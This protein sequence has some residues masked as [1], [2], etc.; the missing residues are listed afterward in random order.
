MPRSRAAVCAVTGAALLALAPVTAHSAPVTRTTTAKTTVADFDIRENAQPKA[1]V[2][3]L[4]VRTTALA[5]IQNELGVQAR[6]DIDDLTGTPRVLAR[7]DGFL[8]GPS[9]LP[10]VEVALNYL[11]DKQSV[12]GLSATDLP[13]L[14]LRKDYVDVAGTRHLSFVQQVDGVPVFGNGLKAHVSKDGRLVQLDGSPVRDLPSALGLTTLSAPGEASKKVAF[15]TGDAVRPAWQT[16]VRGKPDEMRLEVVDA[17]SGTLLYRENLIERQDDD[18]V[19][20]LMWDTYAGKQHKVD[21]SG[22]GWLPVGAKT[23]DGN[24]AHVFADANGD[25]VAQPEEEIPAKKDGSFEYKFTDFTPT[26]GTPCSALYRCTWNPKDP[27]SWK[28][29]RNQNAVQVQSYIGNFHDHLAAF[30]IGFTRAAGNFEK[31]DGD[32]VTAWTTIGAGTKDTPYNNAFFGT[33]PD[34]ESP[35]MGMFLFHDPNDPNDQQVPGN[36]GDTADIVYHEYVHGLSHRLVVDANGVAALATAQSGAMGEA[37]SDWYAHDYLVDKKFE[38]DTSAPGEIVFGGALSFGKNVFRFQP[39]DCAVGAPASVCPGTPTAGPGGFTYGD[40]GRIRGRAQVHADSEIWSETLWDLRTALGVTLTRSLVTRAMELSP[41][42]PSFLDMRNSILQADTVVNGGQAHQQIWKVFAKR[43]MGFFAGA[44]GG[45][46]I[47]P[48]EDFTT[49]PRAGT[50]TGTLSGRVTN[51]ETGAPAQG[52]AVRV[53]GHDSGFAGA[54][55]A[56]SDADGRYAITDVVPGTYPKVVAFGQGYDA[57]SRAVP[58]RSGQTTADWLLDLNWATVAR[59]AVVVETNGN[60]YAEIGC[61]AADLLVQTALGGR[62]W[63]TDAKLN[64][65]GSMQPKFVTIKLGQAIDLSSVEVEPSGVCG[66]DETASARDVTVETSVDGTTWVLASKVSFTRADQDALRSVP[67]TAGKDDVRYLRLT[68]LSNQ[69]G[70][71]P[72]VNCAVPAQM[73]SGCFYADIG[74]LR[75][76]GS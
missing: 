26:V 35:I 52:V 23:L 33:P 49:P 70:L 2:G 67:L 30:P 56:V 27:E 69:V 17:G 16:I 73:R 11:R 61:G 38:K 46:D 6:V 14:H 41:Q 36:A 43:G 55:V 75:V 58:V 50:P 74:G 53:G 21:L 5:E 39:L 47:T 9:S 40:F 8:T 54:K 48:A 45:E 68:L 37:W 71:Y 76:R 3:A 28:V 72:E 59:D 63:S 65:D 12:V 1:E 10:P 18:S 60:E 62:P 34:G 42:R 32:A 13:K 31:V 44:L 25:Q 20:G 22:R 4:S 64:P 15:Y 29:N 51:A 19:G 57:V 66:D 7:T 24:V